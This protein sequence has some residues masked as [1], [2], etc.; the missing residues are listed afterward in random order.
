MDEMNTQPGVFMN[1]RQPDEITPEQIE[2]Q[3]ILL[4]MIGEVGLSPQEQSFQQQTF[5]E[6]LNPNMSDI[7]QMVQHRGTAGS[8]NGQD[9]PQISPQQKMQ[10]EASREE[11]TRMK[12]LQKMIDLKRDEMKANAEERQR[13]ERNNFMDQAMINAA[14]KT[15]TGAGLPGGM[16]LQ[17]TGVP[18]DFS[19]FDAQAKMLQSATELSLKNL[20]GIENAE[21]KKHLLE[22]IGKKELAQGDIIKT[23]L[24]NVFKGARP[25]SGSDDKFTDPV[26]RQNTIDDRMHKDFKD[27]DE[28]TV[29]ITDRRRQRQTGQKEES[30][31]ENKSEYTKK[32]LETADRYH[33]DI[34]PMFQYMTSQR[35]TNEQRIDYVQKVINEA[36][37]AYHQNNSRDDL[38]ALVTALERHILPKLRNNELDFNYMLGE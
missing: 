19:G 38:R 30:L 31:R 3:R 5:N 1:I 7:N 18:D 36:R 35:W 16:L 34:T 21:I 33:R 24:A 27:V 17:Q 10:L 11:Q 20:Y 14:M 37:N 8:F 28:M 2:M 23:G 29:P 9:V 22:T 12:T 13:Q 6:L 26:K 25:G 4:N 32:V 15:Y